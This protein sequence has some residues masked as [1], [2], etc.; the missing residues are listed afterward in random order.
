MMESN[1][2]WIVDWG[3][4]IAHFE[5]VILDCRFWILDCEIRDLRNEILAQEWLE[6]F[7]W[8]KSNWGCR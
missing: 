4:W 6:V 7:F 1:G 5:L 8:Q 2:F 3:F